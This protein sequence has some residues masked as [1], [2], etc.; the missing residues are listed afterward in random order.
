MPIPS[1]RKGEQE[2]AFIAR[3]MGDGLMKTDYK[4]NKQRLAVC[5]SSWREV[6]GGKPPPPAKK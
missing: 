5:Y 4:D 2:A 3:C 6:H 1:P